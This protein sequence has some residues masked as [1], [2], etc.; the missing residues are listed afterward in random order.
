MYR[1]LECGFQDSG[2]L[3]DNMKELITSSGRC[4]V[5]QFLN[6]RIRPVCGYSIE[7]MPQE[8]KNMTPDRISW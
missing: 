5:Q 8:P 2:S 4:S 7:Q 1:A 6:V 3:L